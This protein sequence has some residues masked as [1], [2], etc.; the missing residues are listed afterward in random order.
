M[1]SFT[2]P[3]V[4]S[5]MAGLL[6]GDLFTGWELR[7]LELSVLSYI[8]IDGAVNEHYLTDEE[9]EKRSSSFILWDEIQQKVRALI[10]GGRTPSSMNLSLACPFIRETLSLSETVTPQL[11]IRFTSRLQDGKAVTQLTLYTA[12]GYKTFSLDKTPERLWEEY[13]PTYFRGKNILLME[14]QS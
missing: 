12:M 4:K 13:V 9:K 7:T 8:E 2:V 3:D 5:F 11:N 1:K 6:T 10:A 14:E